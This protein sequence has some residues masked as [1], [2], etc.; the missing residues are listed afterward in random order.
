[1]SESGGFV[2]ISNLSRRDVLRQIALALTAAGTGAMSA[3]SAQEVHRHTQEERQRTGAYEPKFFKAH[4]YQAVRRLAELIVPADEQSGSALDAGAPEFIDLLCS[5]NAE[6]G[7][8]YSGGLL[9]LDA[10]MRQDHAVT[11]L[12]AAEPQQ[13]AML[14][15]L[16]EADGAA[17][18]AS[19]NS[20]TDPAAPYL[21]F[22]EYGLEPVGDLSPGVGFFNWVRRMTV[23]AYYTS[24]IGT[25]DL[26]YEGNTALSEYVVPQDIIDQAL[27]RSPFRA[28]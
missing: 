13:I 27:R 24:P 15:T 1:M 21:R 19:P 11:F 14:N 8:I 9:W 16:V 2:P 23:D 6:L 18:A 12:Q 20:T 17:R 25:K 4:E 22:Q 10:R 26:G 28:G 7:R 3:A 5:E